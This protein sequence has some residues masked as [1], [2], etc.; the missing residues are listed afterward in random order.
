MHGTINIKLT[1]RLEGI[2]EVYCNCSGFFSQTSKNFNYSRFIKSRL[3]WKRPARHKKSILN[4]IYEVG[5]FDCDAEDSSVLGLYVVYT[6]KQYPTF[7]R[8]Y[9]PSKLKPVEVTTWD[10]LA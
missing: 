10:T 2:Y 9:S 4:V 5:D 8:H 3:R 7:R 6:G 1:R